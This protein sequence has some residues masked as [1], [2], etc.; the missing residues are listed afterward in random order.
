MDICV[1]RTGADSERLSILLRLS[2]SVCGEV[3]EDVLGCAERLV[4]LV[5][6]W[7]QG[8]FGG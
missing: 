1:D 8:G 4:D 2:F 3:C 7:V 6:W 5:S